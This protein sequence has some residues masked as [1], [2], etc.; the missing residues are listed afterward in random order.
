M[1]EEVEKCVNCGFCESVCPTLPASG[2]RSTIGARGRVDLGKAFIAE[3]NN[4]GRSELKISDSFYS[5]L[6]CFACLQV[7]PAGVNAGKV[8]GIGREIAAIYG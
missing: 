3:M 2:F 7:C 6:D 1:K 8:S 5:C 4:A